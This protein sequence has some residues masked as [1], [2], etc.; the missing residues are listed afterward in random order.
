[1]YLM[2]NDF[3]SRL[4]SP[5]VINIIMLIHKNLK[6]VKIINITIILNIYI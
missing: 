4:I 5:R 3:F 1:M 6:R 2:M